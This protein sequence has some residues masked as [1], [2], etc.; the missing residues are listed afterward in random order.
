MV[1]V[2]NGATMEVIKQQKI[3]ALIGLYS[4]PI[5]GIAGNKTRTA[6]DEFIENESAL[7]P[8]VKINKDILNDYL[9]IKA[10]S[11]NQCLSYSNKEELAKKVKILCK[12]M[13][14]DNK[15]IWSYVMATAEWETN[16]LFYPVSEAYYLKP[17]SRQVRY[18]KSHDYWPCYGVGLTQL[19]WWYNYKKYS[20]LLSLGHSV[21]KGS[22]SEDVELLQDMFLDPAISLFVMIH[23]M[24]TGDFT[25]RTLFRYIND[26]STDY[27]NARRTVNGTD[28]AE[29]I[30][31]LAEKWE[32]YYG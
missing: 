29:D 18:L 16:G 23:G 27:L 14:A 13:Y 25:G 22:T 10:D 32:K 8:R 26:E 31:M 19:T 24:L 1:A 9:Q 21:N 6:I 15:A 2:N 28:K 5:D 4:A 17:E 7:N 30:A 12:I 3:L 20:D 11:L